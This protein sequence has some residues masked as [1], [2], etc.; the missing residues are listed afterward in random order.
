MAPLV[1]DV[2]AKHLVLLLAGRMFSPVTVGPAVGVVDVV[3]VV[4]VVVPVP[5]RRR[6]TPVWHGILP[7]QAAPG[8]GA[9]LQLHEPVCGIPTA[10]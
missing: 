1:S 7:E 2:A 9:P 10:A 5:V 4:V 8:A 6:G 3:V